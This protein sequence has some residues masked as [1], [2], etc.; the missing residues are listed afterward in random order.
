M[1]LVMIFT[2]RF[3][4]FLL[5][6]THFLMSGKVTICN[7]EQSTNKNKRKVMSLAERVQIFNQLDREV[8]TAVVGCHHGVANKRLFSSRKMKK[9]SREH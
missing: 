9:K 7:D 3:I 2:T 6:S 1:Q 4:I 5:C 8:T